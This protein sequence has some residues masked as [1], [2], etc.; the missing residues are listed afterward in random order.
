MTA[1]NT[2]DFEPC[3]FECGDGVL[4]TDRR[5]LTHPQESICVERRAES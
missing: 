3:L 1:F 2:S 5:D 4:A